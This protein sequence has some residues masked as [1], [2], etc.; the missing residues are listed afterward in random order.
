MV[1]VKF[2]YPAVF[3]LE[4]DGYSVSFPDLDGCF[5]CGDNLQ[6]SIEMAVDASAGWLLTAMD[7]NEDIPNP[8]DVNDIELEDHQ[9]FISLIYIDLVE[10]LEKTD[11]KAVKKTLTIPSWLNKEAEKLNVNFS[12]ILQDALKERL[13][14][15]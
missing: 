7:L 1:K 13:G 15:K 2:V 4:E 10:Y 12:G 11:N 3:H 6:E 14:V 5:T 9:D 8:S